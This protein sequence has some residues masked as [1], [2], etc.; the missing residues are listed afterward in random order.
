MPKLTI[1]NREITVAEEIT[2]LEA[3]RK[4]GIEIPTLCYHQALG[5]YG[6]CRVCL[7]EVIYHGRSKLTTACTYPAWDG[8]EV[9]TDTERVKAARKFIVELLLARSPGVEQIQELAQQLG[10]KAG[11]LRSAKE[12][13][14]CILCGLCIRACQDMIGKSAIS[15]V[16]RGIERKVETP[17]KVESKDCIGCGTCAFVCPTGAIKIEDTQ[18]MRKL[19]TCHLDLELVK[20]AACDNHFVPLK[21]LE[22]IKKRVELPAEIYGLCPQCRRKKLKQQ[23]IGAVQ[24]KL[25]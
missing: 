25:K 7:V 15:F 23:I 20:C 1:D 11:K 21:D 2:V 12:D 14:E 22:H 6:A 13:E 19:T 16:E 8:I 5:P 9:K 10:V 3:A 24:V 18:K 4:L 17:F